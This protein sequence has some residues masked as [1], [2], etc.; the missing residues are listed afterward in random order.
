MR[1]C[2]QHA[3]CVAAVVDI[4]LLFRPDARTRLEGKAIATIEPCALLRAGVQAA[5]PA[6]RR[7]R[8]RLDQSEFDEGSLR[9]WVLAGARVA[10]MLRFRCCV[11][12]RIIG[13][14]LWGSRAPAT[15]TWGVK[16]LKF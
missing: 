7:V 9:W 10:C 8:Q 3:A 16:T 6:G 12:A 4:S 13:R 11:L 15:D 5:A 2:K 14:A 1:R